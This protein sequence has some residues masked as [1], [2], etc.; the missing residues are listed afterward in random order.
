MYKR[1]CSDTNMSMPFNNEL[2]NVVLFIG[3][4]GAFR[5]ELAKRGFCINFD[6]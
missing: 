2:L 6:E 5:V 4:Y 3:G 1:K